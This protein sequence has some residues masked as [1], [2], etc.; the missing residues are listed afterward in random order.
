MDTEFKKWRQVVMNNVVSINRGKVLGAYIDAQCSGLAK[1]DAYF[2]AGVLSSLV[3]PQYVLFIYGGFL[4]LIAFA[5]TGLIGLTLGVTRYY[6]FPYRPLSCFDEKAEA[7]M[8]P[9]AYIQNK[10]A[11]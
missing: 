7:R 5:I 6:W 3:L 8:P 11:A 4:A 10:K 1:E 9:H 2:Y